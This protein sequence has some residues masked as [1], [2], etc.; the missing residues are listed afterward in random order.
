MKFKTFVHSILMCGTAIIA[1]ALQGCSDEVM[2]DIPDYTASDVPVDLKVSVALPQMDVKSRANLTNVQLNTVNN[3]W[4]RTYSADTRQ[5]TSDWVKVEEITTI[6][7]EVAR[8]VTIKSRSGRS[9]IVAVANVDNMGVTSTDRTLKPISTLLEDADTWDKF[10]DI[11][12][13]APSN[14]ELVRAPNVPLTMAGCYSDIVVGGTHPEPTNPANWQTRDF[15][16]YFIPARNGV[17]DFTGQGAIH[18]RRLVSHLNFRV[19]PGN[20]VNV[21]VNSYQVMNAPRYSWLYERSATGG[22]IAN[23]G[24]QATSAQNAADVY[25]AD[26]PQYGAQYVN[27]TEVNNKKISTFDFWQAENKHTG[28][29]TDYNNRDALG[30][31]PIRFTSLTD[32][33]WTPNNEASYVLV[34]CSVVYETDPVVDEYGNPDPEGEKV[35]RTGEA[36]YLIHLGYINNVPTDFNCFRNVDYTYTLTVNGVDDIRLDAIA[37]E[38]TYHGEEGM[39]VDLEYATIDIDAHYAAFNI[40]L[41]QDELS[42]GNFGFII[43]AYEDGNQYIIT[44]AN[45]QRQ[46]G[47]D[48]YIYTSEDTPQGMTPPGERIDPKYY[49]WIELRPTTDTEVL[50][51]YKPRFGD[52]ADGKTF[53]LTDLKGGLSA[54]EGKIS[55]KDIYTVFVNEYTYEPIYTGYN[56]YANE[57][58]TV[59]GHPAWMSYVNENPRRFYIRTTQSVSPDGNSV[60]ARS[61]YGVSQSSIM[62]FFSDQVYTEYRTAIGVERDNETLGMNLRHTFAGGTS[63]AN[64]RWNTG[65]WLNNASTTSRN[66]SIN[67]NDVNNRPSWT[68]YID[69]QTQL[70][71]PAVGRQRAQ[72]GPELPERSPAIPATKR[73]QNQNT[74]TFCDAQA[75]AAYNIEAINA[76]I[77]RNRDNNGNGRIEPDELRWY[78]PARDQYLRMMLGS[79]SLSEPMMDFVKITSLPRYSGNS[80]VTSG[81]QFK[82]DY[83]SRYMYVGSNSGASVMWVMEGTSTSTY[84]E[85]V[86]NQWSGGNSHPW[87][88]R[89]IRNLGT[90]LTTVDQDIK[91][92]PPYVH[93]EATRTFA[94]TYYDL[95]SIRTEKYEGNGDGA[96]MMPLHT[97]PQPYNRTYY[98]FEYAAGNYPVPDGNR[99]NND[100][101]TSSMMSYINTN[102]CAEIMSGQGT[103]WR[104]PNQ[105]ELTIMRNSGVFDNYTGGGNP[106]W[107]SCTANY[108]SNQGVGSLATGPDKYF[109]VVMATGTQANTGNVGTAGNNIF[110]RC[111]R[112]VMP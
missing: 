66:L 37:E 76:C 28:T 4:L 72:N 11:A 56:G 106:M 77:S 50:A 1:A 55:D 3:V 63:M 73:V 98:G 12:V 29:A 87:Q 47:Q 21:T 67:S 30:T 51:E 65:M 58:R 68:T 89:C 41:S 13:P 7:T 107:M 90:N 5:A 74:T 35:K 103:G 111:V 24:D 17:V 102:P 81:G 109:L 105:E 39:V 101:F 108:F 38:E 59:N 6:D 92:L 53:L 10:L 75:N 8:P 96:G 86:S 110:I 85:V 70:K 27:T 43:I 25:Y 36:T 79:S 97:I 46:V 54:I 31:N 52:N 19:V 91:V 80:W 2:P 88:I 49:N 33:D 99:P 34:S 83:C 62:T 18:L 22:M 26:I 104:V 61:K 60:Y 93:N 15:Q 14:S 95:Q 48:I 32:A 78:V 112:D 69:P 45:D 23:F 42:D 82:N 71:I 44:D 64:G 84:D 16:P 40:K 57:E 9:Y 20:N 94:M 100:N